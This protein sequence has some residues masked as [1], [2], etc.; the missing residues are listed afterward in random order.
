[1]DYPTGAELLAFLQAAKLLDNPLTEEQSL[2]DLEG[3]MAGV[4]AD[5]EEE[6]QWF[7]FLSGSSDE[8][9][10]FD[11]PVAN[12]RDLPL[13]DLQGGLV[14]LTGVEVGGTVLT[15]GG[16]LFTKPDNALSRGFPI[17]QLRFWSVS[18][19]AQPN[20]IGVTGRWGYV[21]SV[22]QGVKQALLCR[23]G[24][25]L[26]PQLLANRTLGGVSLWKEGDVEERYAIADTASLLKQWEVTYRSAVQRYRRG[27]VA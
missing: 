5:W 22:P 19:P 6:V 1:M 17:Q 7:P 13:L 18:F 12:G 26:A 23:A 15:V 2:L 16:Q 27:G 4:V 14:S 25:L 11:R 10:Y 24:L 3:V 21:G 20:C 9:R 8:T